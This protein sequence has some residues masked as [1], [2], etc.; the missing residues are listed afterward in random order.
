MAALSLLKPDDHKGLEAV[1]Q[2]RAGT[3]EGANLELQEG[4]VRFYRLVGFLCR[5]WSWAQAGAE[6]GGWEDSAQTHAWRD[7]QSGPGHSEAACSQPAFGFSHAECLHVQKEPP[8][9]FW[10]RR[11]PRALST[12]LQLSRKQTL[13]DD[14]KQV[15]VRT[16]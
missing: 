2:Q 11:Q 9:R 3:R 15:L 5:A 16:E 6:R 10:V 1:A 14:S 13:G 8:G 12:L 4:T 7:Q